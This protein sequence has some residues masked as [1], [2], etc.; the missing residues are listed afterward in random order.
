MDVKESVVSAAPTERSVLERASGAKELLVLAPVSLD[1]RRGRLSIF[2]S[3]FYCFMITIRRVERCGSLHLQTQGLRGNRVGVDRRPTDFSRSAHSQLTHRPS[4][5]RRSSERLQWRLQC[6][7][8]EV[9]QTLGEKGSPPL[10]CRPR[11]RPVDVGGLHC[12][13]RESGRGASCWR[14]IAH[15]E[16]SRPPVRLLGGRTASKPCSGQAA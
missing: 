14:A 11:P 13:L 2:G 1:S 6:S 12:N 9:R 16:A 10:H 7:R 3:R 8:L 4:S 5:R 15:Q